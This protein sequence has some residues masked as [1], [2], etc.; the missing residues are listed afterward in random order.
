MAASRMARGPSA[1]FL[2]AEAVRQEVHAQLQAAQPGAK[3]S[4]ATV[5]KAIGEKWQALT[6][7]EKQ[8][9]KTLAAERATGVQGGRGVYRE[10]A[11]WAATVCGGS[12]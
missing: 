12:A 11:C 4:V 7:E 10:P 3:V 2:F 6:E 9:Y 1:Y 8:A 5:G